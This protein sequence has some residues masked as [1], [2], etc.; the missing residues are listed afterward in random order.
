L[1]ENGIN[2]HHFDLSNF[3][4]NMAIDSP[5]RDGVVSDWDLLE[6]VWE[7]SISNFLNTD[8]KDSPVLVAEKSYNTPANRH[9]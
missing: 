7:H 8:I 1:N 9:K 5:L 4:P 6:R 3:R 2:S